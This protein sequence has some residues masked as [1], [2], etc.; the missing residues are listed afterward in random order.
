MAYS[1]TSKD[2]FK[3]LNYTGNGSTN[4]VTG[5]GF[6]PDLCILKRRDAATTIEV[7]DDVRGV[8][9]RLQTQNND[10]EDNAGA[11][12]SSVT[13]FGTDGF[14]LGNHG[15]V[16]NN[17]SVHSS[18]SWKAAGSTS[19]N[20][21][22]SINS[23]VSVN[24]TAGFS[25]VKWSGDGSAATIG[26]GLGKVPEYI[27][28]K[29]HDGTQQWTQ[30]N[31]ALGAG[32]A[33]QWDTTGGNDAASTYFNNTAPTTTV[34]SV[35]NNSRTN[36]NGGSFIAYVYAPI[37]GYSHFGEYRGNGNADGPFVNCGFKP[38]WV[39]LKNYADSSGTSNNGNY[40][41]VFDNNNSGINSRNWRV[42][43]N[44]GEAEAQT[45]DVIDFYSHGFKI[46]SS[47]AQYNSNQN[48]YVYQAFAEAPLVGA[49]N[50]PATAR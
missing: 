46:R 30:Y 9:K 27:Q 29:N 25:I 3:T 34:F 7:Y 45:A 14:T 18:W 2:H 11:S 15:G 10:A 1:I 36:N 19:T 41:H 33:M 8:E 22:G 17:S 44:S 31:K 32:K 43:W 39:S 21:A 49:G 35:G 6:A 16:N 26:H 37:V 13:A 42:H 48:Y 12:G 38:A 23:T 24:A 40:W 4:A 28:V 20:T 5:V 50:I 47:H